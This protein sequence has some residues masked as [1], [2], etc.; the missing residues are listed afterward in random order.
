MVEEDYC[1]VDEEDNKVLTDNGESMIDV[2][3]KVGFIIRDDGF[4]VLDRV[5]IGEV[6]V[7][8]ET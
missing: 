5:E 8:I 2:G 3:N 6:I 1:V 4:R 7:V